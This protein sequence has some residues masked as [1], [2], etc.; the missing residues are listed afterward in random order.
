MRRL[1]LIAKHFGSHGDRVL[2]AERDVD[3]FLVV[4]VEIAEDQAVGSVGVV[5]PSFK[6]GSDVLAPCILDLRA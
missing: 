4:P 5:L 6:Y 2:G 3:L 1:T